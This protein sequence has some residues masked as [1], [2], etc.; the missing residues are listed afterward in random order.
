MNKKDRTLTAGIAVLSLL[1]V[2]TLVFIFQE[3]KKSSLQQENLELQRIDEL[4]SGGYG[5]DASRA[6]RDLAKKDLSA[7]SYIRLLKRAYRL[8]AFEGNQELLFETAEKAYQKYPSGRGI[9]AVYI[10]TLLRRGEHERAMRILNDAELD[11]ERWKSLIREVRLYGTSERAVSGTKREREEGLARLSRES[12][13]ERFLE[14]YKQT[15]SIGFLQDAVLL[16]LEEGKVEAAYRLASDKALPQRLLFYISYDAGDWPRAL[17]ILTEHPR[18]FPSGEGAFLRADVLMRMERYGEAADIYRAVLKESLPESGQSSEKERAL[19]NLV[20][21]DITEDGRLGRL[22]EEFLP[23]SGTGF[24]RKNDE[25][26][27]SGSVP[28]KDK[29]REKTGPEKEGEDGVPTVLSSVN[30]DLLLELAELMIAHKLTAEAEYFMTLAAGSSVESTKYRFLEENLNNRINP[31]RYTS[32]LWRMAERP[33]YAAH[34]GWFL[35][36]MEDLAGLQSLVDFGEKNFGDTY[37]TR[38]FQGVLKI[39]SEEYERAEEEFLASHRLRAHWVS[40]YNA[41]LALAAQGKINEAL[42]QL[43]E[44]QL[45]LE[46]EDRGNTEALV[47][48]LIKKAELLSYTRSFSS[49]KRVL[50]RIETIDPLNLQADILREML[51]GESE[52]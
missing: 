26:N 47:R 6:V 29:Y 31:E 48:I 7:V 44:A 20:W 42:S 33:E 46:Q 23:G 51:A 49:A 36:G 35:L 30:S 5:E 8:A 2:L 12:G 10:Y 11:E 24:I 18:I 19:F 38:F 45:F 50:D 52:R 39:Y 15:G 17:H 43:E 13:A 3:K 16:L 37:W 1:L 22:T 41:V 25:K 4:L 28:L 14:L 40:L 21:I 9:A 27:S 34:L 32:L